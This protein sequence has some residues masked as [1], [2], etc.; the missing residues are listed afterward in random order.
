MPWTLAGIR[1]P[2]MTE[3]RRRKEVAL[4]VGKFLLHHQEATGTDGSFFFYAKGGFL[5]LTGMYDSTYFG[6]N[7]K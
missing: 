4:S 3:F 6:K 1:T 7:R 2:R 5:N